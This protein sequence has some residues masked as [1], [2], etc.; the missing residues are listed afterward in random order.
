MTRSGKLIAG[1]LEMYGIDEILLRAGVMKTTVPHTK[2]V[3]QI[4]T[5]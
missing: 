3:I 5:A 4:R 2:P 1:Y